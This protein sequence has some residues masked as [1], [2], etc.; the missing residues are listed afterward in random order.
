MPITETWLKANAGKPR[1]KVEEKSDRDSLSAR[2]SAKGKITFQIRFRFDGKGARIDLGSYPLISLKEAREKALE[3]RSLIEKGIDPR[4]E[5]K[6][7]KINQDRESLTF[8]GI[9]DEWHEKY[10][11]K[12][13]KSAND[14]YRSFELYVFKEFGDLPA[15]RISVRNWLNLLEPLAEQKPSITER[16][17]SNTKQMYNWA[18]KRELCV[19]NPLANIDSKEDLHIEYI[20]KDRTLNDQ[21]IAYIWQGLMRSRMYIRNRIF[22][23]LCFIY[24][25]RSGELRTAKKEH[26]DKESM[27]WIIPPENHKNGEKTR[28][29]IIRPLIPETL[30]LFELAATLNDSE[31][32]F[33]TAKNKHQPV[34][35]GALLSLPYDLTEYLF[36]EEQVTLDHWSLHDLRRTFRTNMSTITEPHIAEIMLGHVLPVIW[37]TYD[38][39]D[40][41]DEQKEA[42]TKWVERLRQIVMPYPLI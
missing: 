12:N 40:Y 2:V 27:T 23:Q 32:L 39:H 22:V 8:K 9:F 18:I 5:K 15:N 3:V 16:I 7:D 19:L 28:K 37:R 30:Q 11:F 20:P 25:C 42:L 21:E 31:Y 1:E 29:P 13:K 10:L 36:R 14:I 4:V 26:I 24:G 6:L 38:K 41:L 17:L 33:V 35:R 34:S